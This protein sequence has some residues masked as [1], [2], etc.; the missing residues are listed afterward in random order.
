MPLN[1]RKGKKKILELIRKMLNQKMYFWNI[2]ILEVKV[3]DTD[4]KGAMAKK[5]TLKH[6]H[7]TNRK[8]KFRG[9]SWPNRSSLKWKQIQQEKKNLQGSQE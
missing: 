5:H 9:T 3:I 2:N 8:G 4:Y 1:V 7:Q 6:T